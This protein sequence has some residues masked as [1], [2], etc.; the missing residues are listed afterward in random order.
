MVKSTVKI[1]QNFVAFSEYMNLKFYLVHGN[2]YKQTKKY[3]YI[4]SVYCVLKRFRNFSLKLRQLTLFGTEGGAFIP[5]SF[6]GSVL[7]AEF[8][9]KNFQN[10]FGDENLHQLGFFDT[11]SAHWVL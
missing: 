10:F 6:F 9:S 2:T 8:F 1:L 3:T 4:W 11:L 5:L 7:S